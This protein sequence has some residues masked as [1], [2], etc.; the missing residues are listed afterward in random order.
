MSRTIPKGNLLDRRFLLKSAGA[1]LGLS[2]I[3]KST[4]MKLAEQTQSGRTEAF[5]SRNAL[6]FM[7]AHEQFPLPH[8]VELGAA[9][10]QA[11]F[12]FVANS[13]HIQPWQ[14]NEG[15]A[16]MSWLTMSALGQKTTH[17]HMGTTVTCPTFRYNPAVVAQAFASLALMYPGRIFLGIGSGEAINEETCVGSWPKW[18]ERSERLIEATEIIRELW[19]GQQVKHAG[20]YYKL[21][22]RLWDVPQTPPLLLMAANGPKAMRRA[23]RYAD[24]LVSDAKTWKQ[25]KAEFESGVKEAGKDPRQVPVLLEQYVVVGEK[26]D[27]EQAGELWRFGPKAFKTYYNIPSPQTIQDRAKTENPMEQVYAE[28]PVS[29][30]PGVHVKKLTE[31]FESGATM[32]NIHSGQSDQRRVIEFYGKQVLPQLRRAAAA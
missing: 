17:L 5:R 22:V 29:T 15:H 31:L 27:A 18:D 10:E 30:D 3:L 14:A 21:D 26:K 28:W 11:G 9:A 4:P 2:S 23:G 8:L 16:G 19:K 24:G 12:D 7:L 13:D 6:G 20:K 1:F 32:V 25:H